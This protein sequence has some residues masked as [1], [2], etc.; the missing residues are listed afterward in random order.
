M[1][2]LADWYGAHSTLINL[3]GINILLA[4]SLYVTLSCAML[5]LANA[6]FMGIGAYTA[7]LLTID[8]NWPFWAVLPAGALAAAAVA[9][10]LGL[11]ILRLRGVFLAIATIGFGEV[12]RIVALSVPLTGGALGIPSIPAKTTWWQ[13]ALAL[14]AISYLLWHVERSRLGHAFAAIRQD[15]LVAASLG[16]NVTAHKLIAFVLGA[17]IAGLAGGLSAHLTHLISPSDFG[18]S[19]AVDI[20]VYAVVGGTGAFWGA[21]PGAA[22]LT[23]LPEWLRVV[24]GFQAAHHLGAF[25]LRQIVTG[26][27]TLL[28]IIFFPSGISGTLILW[29]RRPRGTAEGSDDDD[30]PA[31]TPPAGATLLHPVP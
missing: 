16:I 23:L 11:P 13:I 29:W 10:P 26:A 12:I 31:T 14:L 5:S 9:V 21:F 4:L 15:E 25:D 8:A 22:L 2:A 17:F 3:T 7:A 30:A 24:A 27:I 19:R 1:A 20:L 28:V 18:F 6:A